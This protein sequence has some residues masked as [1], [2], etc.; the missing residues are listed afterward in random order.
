MFEFTPTPY[1]PRRLAQTMIVAAAAGILAIAQHNAIAQPTCSSGFQWDT[2]F[3]KGG[4][5]NPATGSIFGGVMFDDLSGNG[6]ELYVSGGFSD[7][8]G[9]FCR[10]GVFRFR[11]GRWEGLADNVQRFAQWGVGIRAMVGWDPDG[12]GPEPEL[13]VLA[14]GSLTGTSTPG[15][16]TWNGSAFQFPFA[17]LATGSNLTSRIE[18]I[19]VWDSNNDGIDELYI[20]GDIAVGPFLGVGVWSPGSGTW[21]APG[22]LGLMG[23]PLPTALLVH[24]DGTGEALYVAGSF[25]GVLTVPDTTNIARFDGT[26]WSSVGGGLPADEK[27]GSLLTFDPDGPGPQPTVLVAI[28]GLAVNVWDGVS[29][30]S[31]PYPG[32]ASG[33]APVTAAAVVPESDGTSAVYFGSVSCFAN[34]SR[35]F[36]FDGTQVSEVVGSDVAPIGDG[37]TPAFYTYAGY[38]DL[39]GGSQLVLDGVYNAPGTLDNSLVAWS[40]N[41]W[42]NPGPTQAIQDR[43]RVVRSMIVANTNAPSAGDQRLVVAGQGAISNGNQ[44]LVSAFDGVV[45]QPLDGP[46]TPISQPNDAFSLATDESGIIHAAFLD[47]RDGQGVNRYSVAAWTGAG[48][49]SLNTTPAGFNTNSGSLDPD[50]LFILSANIGGDHDLFAYGRFLT[51]DGNTIP[52]V[53]RWDGTGW[54]ALGSGLNPTGSSIRTRAVAFDDGAGTKLFVSGTFNNAGGTPSV[55]GMAYWNGATWTD[56][57]AGLNSTTLYD[58]F[59]ADGALFAMQNLAA[60]NAPV[61]KWNGAAWTIVANRP[62]TGHTSIRF[63]PLGSADFN[64]AQHAYFSELFG[65]WAFDGD[66][67][68]WI[69]MRSDTGMFTLGNGATCARFDIN[70]QESLFVGGA[71]KGVDGGMQFS[72]FG[73]FGS[74]DTTGSVGLARWHCPDVIAEPCPCDFNNNGLQEIGDYFSFLTAFFAQLGGQ[75]SA[76]F[77]NDGTV[78]IGDY[79]A[80]L[81]CLPDIAASTTCP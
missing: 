31:F 9:A 38:H 65:M 27:P 76:D 56:A 66:T 67:N 20:V 6:Q 59:I 21:D 34:Q 24:N 54:V 16:A 80:F 79:F 15:I 22:G 61:Y 68:T 75:G 37:S 43:P 47:G 60:A 23:S 14:G 3:G 51:I 18:D 63:A 71:F 13:L 32:G 72:I 7:L 4:S 12:A 41:H 58:L 81:S 46:G 42:I 44:P 40:E 25:S 50:P 36:R 2:S 78:T 19:V 17:S 30:T 55:R 49:Q 29:W 73:G 26:N 10:T 45:W 70:G 53:A 64:N 35:L 5:S 11:G 52:G 39:G 69:D 48:W 8:D 77:D 1:A 28:T 74:L 57:S 62:A 33:C